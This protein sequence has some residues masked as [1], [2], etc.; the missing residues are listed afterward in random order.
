M[1][2]KVAAVVPMML[3]G[4]R[5]EERRETSRETRSDELRFC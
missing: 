1:K 4:L 2:V 3:L 5:M